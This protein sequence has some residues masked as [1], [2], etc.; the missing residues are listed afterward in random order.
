MHVNCSLVISDFVVLAC[1]LKYN[2]NLYP[3]FS[4]KGDIPVDLYF[5]MVYAKFIAGNNSDQ[6]S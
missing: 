5:N 4:L 2:F 1:Q 3:N 6:L